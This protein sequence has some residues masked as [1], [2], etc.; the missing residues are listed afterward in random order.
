MK[1]DFMNRKIGLLLL[2]TGI[3]LQGCAGSLP[4][5]HKA[6]RDG[7]IQAIKELISAGV[8]PDLQTQSGSTP[9]HFAV[10]H[11]NLDA[12]KTLLDM[13][14]DPNKADYRGKT[15]IFN[16]Y[17]PD[18]LS[19]LLARGAKIEVKNNDGFG[20]TPLHRVIFF[21]EKKYELV[22][23]LLQADADPNE[24]D[25]IG[26]TPLHIAVGYGDEN[27]VSILIENGA[28]VNIENVQGLTPRDIAC[29]MGKEKIIKILDK[30]GSISKKYFDKND[31]KAQVNRGQSYGNIAGLFNFSNFKRNPG[32]GGYRFWISWYGDSGRHVT[33]LDGCFFAE[34]G[35]TYI[36][37]AFGEDTLY[38]SYGTI[39][40]KTTGN[41][42]GY[43]H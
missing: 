25:R 24:K 22:K 39:R 23:I 38:K 33:S 26:F 2:F 20:Y 30:N 40:D 10:G 42:V 11:S 7:N 9:L 14:A 35:Q 37:D 4:K 32:L 13:G 27:V 43:F 16:A 31:T 6:G 28:N 17:S 29:V 12:V 5:I 3:L 15:A 41:I 21:K 1:E 36:I 8:S 19:E 34:P 18:I